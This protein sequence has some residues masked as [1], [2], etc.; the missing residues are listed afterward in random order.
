MNGVRVGCL[1]KQLGEVKEP[2]NS[3][4]ATPMAFEPIGQIRWTTRWVFGLSTW[5]PLGD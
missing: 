5:H 3:L 1:I 2:T 4:L